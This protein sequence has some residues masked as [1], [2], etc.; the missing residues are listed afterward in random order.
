MTT[1]LFL[2]ANPRSTPKLELQ[3]EADAIAAALGRA[4]YAGHF[5]FVT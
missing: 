3:K 5:R 4:Q 2:A 1:I